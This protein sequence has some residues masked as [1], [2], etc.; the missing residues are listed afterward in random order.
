MNMRTT[1][2]S[3]LLALT[4]TG[5][6]AQ[7]PPPQ[8][9]AWPGVLR[10]EVDARDIG[11]R[12]FKVKATI[13]A[14]P[15]PLT[16]LYPQWLPGA[17]S[18]SG[19]IDK[20]AGLVVTANGKPLQWTRDQYDVYAFKVDVPD[21]A[22]EV[23]AEFKFLSSQGGS[24]GRVVMTPEMLNLQWNANS[25]YP[26]GVITRNLQAQASVTLPKGWNYATALET[27]RRDGDTVVFKP[28]SYDHLVDSPLFAGRYYQQFDLDPGAKV[29]V[30]LN[31]FADDAKSLVAK[32]EQLQ[33]HR[34]LVQQIYKLYGARHFDHYDFLLALTSKL[35]GIGL[36]HQRSSENSAEPGYFTEWDKNWLGRDLLPHEFNH[37]WNGK[38]RRGADLSTPNFN[39]P[40]GD[41]LLWLYEGQTQFW[42]QVLAARSGLWSVQQ[43]RETLAN[44][45]ATYDRGRPGLAWRA[46]QDTTNDPTIAQRRALA[47]RNYQLSEDY[48]SGGQMVWLEVEGKLRALTGNKRSLD[49][50]AKAFFGVNDGDWNVHP[51]TFEDVVRTLNGI[52]PFD[53]AS[54][55]RERLDGH[56]SLTGGLE[57]AGWKLVYTDTPSDAV[58]A[59]E[60][61]AAGINL[62]YS[63]GVSVANSGVLTD[64]LWDSPAFNAG[65]APGMTVLAVNGRV[66]KGDVLKDAVAAAKTDKTPIT[67]LVRSFDRIDTVSLDYHGGL[68]YPSL[69]RIAG[70]PDRLAELW[71]AR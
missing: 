34:A 13:P 20:V 41:S 33:A 17:H 4:A 67:L 9:V 46:L 42:G 71:K 8:D 65:L 68:L 30:R 28:I 26:A 60:T 70:K 54:F 18:P 29:P 6:Q 37:S 51:Y 23:V 64:V 43:T 10:I 2:L 57:A 1:V 50:F 25:L 11:R 32:P 53:W 16:L 55:L 61:R 52:A 5:I 19:P 45:A 49:D 69:Q 66:F 62:T 24:Q 56:G 27:E 59:Q 40:M 31:V 44:V 12:I 35:G 36:E 3:V 39:V 38:Y 63:L 14:R 21:G 48:Y 22:S 7:T 47:F 15:G 58:K